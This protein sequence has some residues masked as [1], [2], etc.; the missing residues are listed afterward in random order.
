MSVAGR[1]PRSDGEKNE[2]I[3]SSRT[4]SWVRQIVIGL[5]LCPFAEPAVRSDTV[6]YVVSRVAHE[7]LVREVFFDEVKLLMAVTPEQISTT[8]IVM[9]DYAT[10]DFLRFHALASSIENE[11]SE[12]EDLVDSILIASFHPN[13]CYEGTAKNDALNFEKRSPYPVINILRAEVLDEYIAQGSEHLTALY[14]WR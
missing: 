12:D 1:A 6:R 13:F 7:S 14:S 2:D 10:N 8:L 9:P 5:G 4:K 11:I 3:V